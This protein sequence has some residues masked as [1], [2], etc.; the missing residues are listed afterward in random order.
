[1]E[2]GGAVT[3]MDW[4]PAMEVKDDLMETSTDGGEGDHSN[5]NLKDET[6]KGT[7]PFLFNK[8]LSKGKTTVGTTTMVGGK[9]TMGKRV[10]ENAMTRMMMK[11]QTKIS[12]TSFKKKKGAKSTSKKR[13]IMGVED[14]KTDSS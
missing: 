12:K 1:M 9:K 13:M 5:V 7:I 6:D 11:S 2:T 14:I 4:T 10:V 3:K 8:M